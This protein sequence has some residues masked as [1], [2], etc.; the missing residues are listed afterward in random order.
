MLSPL[1][2]PPSLPRACVEKD[3]LMC[4]A[5]KQEI[6]AGTCEY[7]SGEG[8]WQAAV[9]VARILDGRGHC[10]GGE[11]LNLSH[12]RVPACVVASVRACARGAE[13]AVHT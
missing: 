13:A 9:L 11:P 6:G 5:G 4:G 1:H 3:Q 10:E 7:Q 2:A 12:R 8:E